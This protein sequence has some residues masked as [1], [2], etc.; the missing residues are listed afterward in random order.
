[1]ILDLNNITYRTG[2]PSEITDYFDRRGY[3]I[4]KEKYS[5][6]S[7]V[8]LTVKGTNYIDRKLTSKKKKSEQK[9]SESSLNEKIDEILERLNKLGLGQEIIYDDF[10]EMR[11]L[12]E[13]L[14]KKSWSQLL[15]G[16]LFDLT[17]SKLL[18]KDTANFIYEFLTNE[19][20]KFLE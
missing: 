15:K 1:M 10:E 13:K 8:H 6:T 11:A 17:V 4:K 20:L 7:I 16:K 12:Q 19:R 3:V 5:D 14:S 9:A 18:N 2:E